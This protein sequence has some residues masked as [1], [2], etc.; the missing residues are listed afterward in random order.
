V[1]NLKTMLRHFV[2]YKQDNWCD[3]LPLLEV[4]YNRSVNP[5]TG[6]SP[7]E[8]DCGWQPRLPHDVVR[9]G[10]TPELAEVDDFIANLR[11]HGE[12]ARL[13]MQ[14][15]Q[16]QQALHYDKKRR[17]VDFDMGDL[18]LVSRKHIRPDWESGRPTA[19]LN[20]RWIGPYKILGKI[21]NNAFR[22]ELPEGVDRIHNVINAEYLRKHRSSPREFGS[23]L[24]ARPEPLFA[25]KDIEI[26]N[27]VS[28]IGHRTRGRGRQF[29]V[30]WEGLRQDESTW[31][32]ESEFRKQQPEM[33]DEY[34][35]ANGLD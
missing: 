4:A 16:E 15:A 3:L 23:R 5:S 32:P 28:I 18:V 17:P 25:D 19:K 34:L 6:Y 13:A 22:L 7:F 1:K 30:H 2:N 20:A 12:V 11:S 35:R 26:R 29:L 8:L 21:N 9:S 14:K 10:S 27:P 31:R 24:A 33:L